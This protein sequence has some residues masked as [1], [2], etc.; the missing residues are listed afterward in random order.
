MV[1]KVQVTAR[2]ASKAEGWDIG[3]VRQLD[4]NPAVGDLHNGPAW[5]PDLSSP[6][7]WRLV[8]SPA[9]DRLPTSSCSGGRFP[10]IGSF[11]IGDCCLVFGVSVRASSSPGRETKKWATSSQHGRFYNEGKVVQ[12]AQSPA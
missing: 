4:H 1:I 9:L 5:N 11:G 12:P 7:N 3:N 6:Q 8:Q 10:E 2:E